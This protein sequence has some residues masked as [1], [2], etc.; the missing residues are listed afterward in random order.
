MWAAAENTRRGELL[1]ERGADVNARSS[2][3]S[4]RRSSS[5]KPWCRRCSRGR[6]DA[7]DACGAPGRRA[8]RLALVDAGADLNPTD[9]DGRARSSWRS[10][11]AT[12]TSRLLLDK[13]AD[14]NVADSP[15][16]RRSTPPWTCTRSSLIDRPA[17]KTTARRQ[18]DIVKML[19]AKAP[20]NARQ[21][22]GAAEDAHGR[23]SG[24]GRGRH[25][26]HARGQGGDV[27]VMRLLLA[28]G[29]DPTCR[30]T[31]RRR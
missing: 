20:T 9:P 23:R 13:G 2:L 19:L 12:T 1:V 14:P 31:R 6:H 11:T 22:R 27:E 10:S 30:R 25:A 5:G 17:P 8:G 24:V 16:W 4:S 15:A 18:P 26:V 3:L 21:G 7:A 29:A 28:K